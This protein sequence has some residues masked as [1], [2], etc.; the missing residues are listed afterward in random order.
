V[1]LLISQGLLQSSAQDAA[2]SWILECVSNCGRQDLFEF[3]ILHGFGNTGFDTGYRGSQ[4][5]TSHVLVTEAV[6]D[7]G[8][9]LRLQVLIL[10]GLEDSL[11]DRVLERRSLLKLVTKPAIASMK[12]GREHMLTSES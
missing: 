7:D 6:D 4:Q 5:S 10:Q 9:D 11:P 8:F 1:Q 3:C 2:E 12:S